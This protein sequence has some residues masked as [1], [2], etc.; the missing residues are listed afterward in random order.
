[1][2]EE[3]HCNLTAICIVGNTLRDDQDL[4][5]DATSFGIKVIFSR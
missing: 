4:I 3:E 5:K 1:M 2:E